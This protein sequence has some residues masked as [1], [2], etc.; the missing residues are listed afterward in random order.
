MRFNN[1]TYGELS[2][3]KALIIDIL[4]PGI[5][6][7]EYQVLINNIYLEK[8]IQ[9]ISSL[10]QTNKTIILWCTTLKC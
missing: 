3:Y 5:D 2:V 1:R 7:I 4:Y 9:G 8:I 10:G 6:I